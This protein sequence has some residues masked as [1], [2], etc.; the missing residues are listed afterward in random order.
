MYNF[1][2]NLFTSDDYQYRSQLTRPGTIGDM[3]YATNTTSIIMIPK[4]KFSRNYDRL[5]NFLSDDIREKLFNHND[6][7]SVVDRDFDPEELAEVLASARFAFKKF[8]CEKCSGDGVVECECCGNES[9]C[10]ECHG[11]GEGRKY[12]FFIRNTNTPS[13]SII[14]MG[15]NYRPVDLELILISIMA[16]RPQTIIVKRTSDNKKSMFVLDDV[17][18]VTQHRVS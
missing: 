13:A 3:V 15:A 8:N 12:D 7:T 5:S 1:V 11:T 9:E 16:L 4:S 17:E 14:F 6:Y 2:L 18:I 10:K